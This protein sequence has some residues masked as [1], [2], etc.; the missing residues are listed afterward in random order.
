[1][2]EKTPPP[3]PDKDKKRADALRRNL[4]RRKAAERGRDEDSGQ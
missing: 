1:M 4:A 2:A 3:K